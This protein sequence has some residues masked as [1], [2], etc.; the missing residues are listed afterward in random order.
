[1]W[2][3]SKRNIC[4][5]K[6]NICNILLLT[7][8]LLYLFSFF[9]GHS[10]GRYT[11]CQLCYH[12]NINYLLL[13]LLLLLLFTR[14]PFWTKKI[15]LLKHFPSFPHSWFITGFV[16]RL[17]RLV[18]LVDQELPTLPE[19]LSSLPVFSGVRVSRS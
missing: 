7:F 4:Y 19:H 14:S 18:P 3:S 8:V 9:K 11:L 13:L 5:Y 2:A 6:K 10:Q 17:T 12:L 1:M 15:L 16:T